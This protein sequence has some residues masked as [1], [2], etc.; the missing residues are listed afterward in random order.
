M[1]RRF[2]RIYVS[3][4]VIASYGSEFQTALMAEL[5]KDTKV[6]ESDKCMLT[7]CIIYLLYNADFDIIEQKEIVP[8]QDDFNMEPKPEYKGVIQI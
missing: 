8:C 5:P 3:L 6:M 1:Q 4:H 7:G 2:K